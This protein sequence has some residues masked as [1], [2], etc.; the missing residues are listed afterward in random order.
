[1][2]K[3]NTDIVSLASPDYS[4]EGSGSET[5][6]E[7]V[8]QAHV[9]LAIIGN[10]LNSKKPIKRVLNW[11][12]QKEI[13]QIG[14]TVEDAIATLG[15]IYESAGI[16]TPDTV[17]E[18][19]TEPGL[20]K[21]ES[22]L[23]VSE[24]PPSYSIAGAPQDAKL[25]LIRKLPIIIK[26]KTE[27]DAEGGDTCCYMLEP[28]ILTPDTFFYTQKGEIMAQIIDP[29][30]AKLE[31]WREKYQI[32]ALIDKLSYL[33]WNKWYAEDKTAE[34]SRATRNK[35]EQE[36]LEAMATFLSVI[37]NHFNISGSSQSAIGDVCV[38]LRTAYNV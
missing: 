34:D 18:P 27:I 23:I 17:I 36:R 9:L 14:K 26:G 30:L 24:Q 11:H 2:I 13:T 5:F 16:K 25:D 19:P 8:G 29:R 35:Y 33:I 3:P 21:F 20:S 37:E 32:I 12:Q 10:A 22:I 6:G 1:M 38:N 4:G 15:G 7:K 28:D 31:K